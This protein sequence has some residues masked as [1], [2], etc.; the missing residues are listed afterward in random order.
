MADDAIK[1]TLPYP[2]SSNRI[3][4]NMRGVM[5]KTQE[6]RQYNL[7]VAVEARRQGVKHPRSEN[8]KIVLDFYRPRRKGDLDN[9]IKILLDSIQ[10]VGF[11]NDSQIVEIHARR[12]DDPKRP[13][14]EAEIIYLAA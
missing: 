9:R 14:V 1:L 3:W 2:P 7:E 4:R 11:I 8:V 6:A 13:R 5:V 12:H 10:G